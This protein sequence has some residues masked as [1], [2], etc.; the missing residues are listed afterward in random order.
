MSVWNRDDIGY[1]FGEEIFY[2]ENGQM[3]SY[4]NYRGIEGKD[5]LFT[6]WD[7]D[8]NVTSEIEYHKDTVVPQI[9]E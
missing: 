9:E 3:K 1:L 4:G 6:T 2:Y 8:G 5:G 7:E